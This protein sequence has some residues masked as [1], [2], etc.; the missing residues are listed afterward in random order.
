MLGHLAVEPRDELR[1]G[2]R[3]QFDAMGL[4]PFPPLLWHVVR[5]GPPPVLFLDGLDL[6]AHIDRFPRFEAETDDRY[7]AG[8]ASL[9]GLLQ[10]L[11]DEGA[12]GVGVMNAEHGDGLV[13]LGELVD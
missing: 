7:F 13:V 12:V 3:V 1:R 4:Q 11:I 5:D 10:R 6:Q 9:G 2:H 8:T